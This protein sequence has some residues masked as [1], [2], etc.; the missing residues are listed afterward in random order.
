MGELLFFSGEVVSSTKLVAETAAVGSQPR[1]P[2]FAVAFHVF[3]T[4]LLALAVD[5]PDGGLDPGLQLELLEE[6]FDVDLDGAHRE[7]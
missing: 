4:L 7:V 1:T 2:R 3:D 5:R 6:M